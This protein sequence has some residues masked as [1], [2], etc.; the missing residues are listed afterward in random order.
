MACPPSGP[1]LAASSWAD[2]YG[3][4]AGPG[5]RP[6]QGAP[7]SGPESGRRSLRP[8][9]E[10]LTICRAEVMP[11]A[12]GEV[13]KWRTTAISTAGR[14]GVTRCRRNRLDPDPQYAE[15]PGNGPDQAGV[16]PGGE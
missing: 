16:P 13:P 8:H 4:A 15:L 2:G 3:L 1:A 7:A 5:L 12:G 6:D 9:T 14:P 11:E 10:R